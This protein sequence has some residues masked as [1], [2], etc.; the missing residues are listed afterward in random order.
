MVYIVLNLTHFQW[1]EWCVNEGVE[2][3]W[4]GWTGEE[5]QTMEC[6]SSPS[7]GGHTE[8]HSWPCRS[9][10]Y[11]VWIKLEKLFDLTGLRLMHLPGLQIYFPPCV[12]P[13]SAVLHPIC[14][15]TVSCIACLS[16]F[17]KILCI[18][19]EKS[20]QKG[21]M[22]GDHLSGKPG[23]VREF[24]SCQGN[25][26]DFAEYQGNV[27]ELSGKKSCRGKVA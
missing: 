19:L 4:S 24:D 6:T 25:V 9:L 7:H 11:A 21:Y 18:V 1:S 8:H 22:Q 13:T 2:C 17:V 15:H 27:M 20:H 14:S 16:G 12:T 23:N 26:R 5:S 10:I 3:G